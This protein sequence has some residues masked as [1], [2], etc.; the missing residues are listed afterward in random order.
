MIWVW[1]AAL[2]VVSVLLLFGSYLQLLYL[3]SLRLINMK[4]PP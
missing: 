4:P 3:E 1:L 2:F